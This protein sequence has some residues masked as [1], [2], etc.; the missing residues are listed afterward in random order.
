MRKLSRSLLLGT[1]SALPVLV[2][3]A[4]PTLTNNEEHVLRG[5]FDRQSAAVQLSKLALEKGSKDSVKKFAQSELDM[6]QKLAEGVAKMDDEFKL[7]TGG[8]AGG[9]SPELAQGV[10]R[11]VETLPAGASWS[12]KQ[13]AALVSGGGGGPGGA[14]PGGGA[15][16]PAGG[17]QGAGGPPGGG[18]GG[19]GAAAGGAGARGAGGGGG[20][21]RY[22]YDLEEMQKLSGADFDKQFVFRVGIAHSAMVRHISDEL[23]MK[24]ANPDL[25]AYAKTALELISA[26]NSNMERLL[27]GQDLSNGPPGGQRPAGGAAGAAG[28]P[29]AG[30]QGGAPRN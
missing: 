25:V 11:G 5:F 13:A 15:G 12:S 1:L 10:T 19:G 2:L 20:N 7:I 24:D 29:P 14:P 3:A 22:T 17:G 6:Y 30:G 21:A 18:G 28:G 23:S 26:Q 27:L 4:V 9:G 8:S 16:R